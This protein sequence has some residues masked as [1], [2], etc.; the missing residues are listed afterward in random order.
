MRKSIP[1]LL[2]FWATTSLHAQSYQQVAQFNMGQLLPTDTVCFKIEYPEYAKLSQK[3]VAKLQA[4]G[5]E[6]Q[7]QVQFN[8]HFS[9]SRGDT[10]VEVDYVPIVNRK[11]AWYEVKNYNLVPYIK[12]PQ[13]PH[14]TR[15]I[16]QNMQRV[17]RINRYANHSVLATGKWVKIRVSK[18]GIYQLTD[19]QLKKAG[20][21][22]PNKVRLYGYGGRL[23]NEKF[24][25]TGS[26][27]L[28]DDLNEVPLYRRSGSLLFFAE[29]VI[30]YQ[31]NTKFT[32]NTFSKYSYYFLTEAQEGET[33]AAF[34][35]LAAN[36]VGNIAQ[37][38]TTV[39]AHALVMNETYMWYG[40]GREFFDEKDLQNG[41]YYR[42]QLPGNTG[43]PCQI[44]YRISGKPG[45][46]TNKFIIAVNE[47]T[48]AKVTKDLGS[49][50]TE[51]VARGCRGSFTANV[52][53][54][55]NIAIVTPATG[56]L[57]Y[58]YAS[59]TQQLSA[60]NPTA[61]FSPATQ[62]SV[63]LHVNNATANTRV[64][65]IGDA[66][67]SLAELPGTLENGTYK[68]IA[69]DGTKRFV[70]AD[71][72][73]SYD[74]PTIVGNIENQDLHAD[75]TYDYVIIVPASGKL[76]AQ[77]ERL[78]K[79]HR[80]AQNL[81]VKVV[82]ADQIYNEFSSGTPDAS[83][84]RRYLKMLYDRAASTADAPRYL[85]LFGNC[86][87]DNRM[88]TSEWKKENP[89]NYLLAYER[90]STE[91]DSG[92]YGIGS[93]N[94][95][96][97]DDY[98]ALL[99]D[100]EGANIT[101]EKIDLGVGRFICTTEE[102]AKQLVD[103][104]QRYLFNRE[105]GAWQNRMW[106]IGDVGDNNLHMQDAE[107]VCKQVTASAND[108][109]M[110]RR[111][112]PDAY[113]ATY[114]AKG[115]TFPE[116]TSR[117]LR[118]MQTGALIF[119]YNGHGSP[120]RLSHSFLLDKEDFSKNKSAT[121]PLWIFA[122]CE[123]T[124]YDQSRNDIGRNVIYNTEGGS[125]GVICASRSV[126]ANYNRSLNRGLIKHLFAKDEN[127]KRYSIGDALRRTKVELVGGSSGIVN[128]IGYDSSRNK[129]K[130][131]LLGDPAIILA[132]A[133][134]GVYIDSINGQNANSTAVTNIPVGGKVT[135]SG[136]VNATEAAQTPDTNFNGTLYATLF[137]PKQHIVCKGYGNS[138]A[139]DYQYDDYTQTLFE[140]KVKVSAGRFTIETIIPRGTTFSPNKCLLSLYTEQDSTKAHYNGQFSNFCINSSTQLAQAD[141]LGP[142]VYL[143]IGT[144]DFPD[145]GIIGTSATLYASVT[146]STGISMMT[147]NL[148]HDME[149]WF[150]GR[151][152]QS[153]VVNDYFT[154]DYGSYMQGTLQYPLSALQV[155]RHTASLRVWD[156]FG[157]ATTATLTFNVQEGGNATA[158][159][160]VIA[161]PLSAT[162]RF[163]T[164]YK[165]GQNLTEAR[166]ILTE[167]YNL[168]GMRVWHNESTLPAGNQYNAVDW[169]Q[170]DYAGSPLPAGVYL[171]RSKM[172]KSHTKTK[173]LIIK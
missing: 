51:E 127:G 149:L 114:E 60:N 153:L 18:E 12:G 66:K 28:I 67:S 116:A 98:Y 84:Y 91:N 11:G 50:G 107:T 9:Q 147:G 171:Y 124:P 81:R 115:T 134:K 95:F 155:G 45:T 56:H 168:T 120:D 76:T 85:L 24:T 79:L 14:A 30:N 15:R 161:V 72:E 48:S 106:A 97:T 136:Y 74:T 167:V 156:V 42:M 22:A 33:P 101:Y 141:T 7:S 47:D 137:A 61:A 2:A 163:I 145:G 83:A 3:T 104:T 62:G 100:N 130:Y 102:E 58:L 35:T 94:D 139:A 126:F 32:T 44:A 113:E 131:A 135:F 64:W 144:P 143:Y 80:E 129:M 154:F 73:K 46:T 49:I 38:V 170:T 157:N 164:N 93:L 150:D 123:I 31:S 19:A 57:G 165:M 16:M 142:N 172:G 140:G 68:A 87:Y 138:S 173:K 105:P 53:E 112:F 27:A 4:L 41:A 110:L 96:V 13:L 63:T 121:L 92:T 103:K 77:A 118:A 86:A 5:F 82:R 70:I 17:E 59:Y 21:N 71:I 20:F 125:L 122:S 89:D 55:A 151:R 69:A 148:G 99:D 166:D 108:A 6:A 1:I 117:I 52:G 10:W 36:E 37:D 54:T 23:L 159:F 39:T 119:N 25:F 75:S 162:T 152:D 65:Q 158:D 133:E 88:I 40:G 160:D 128:T 132:Y 43:A 8:P 78:A 34:S 146:D 109:F 29:G 26:D 111:V 90:S 169:N